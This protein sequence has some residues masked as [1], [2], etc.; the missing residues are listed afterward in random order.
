[1]P[2]G[3][4]NWL[5]QTIDFVRIVI[6]FGLLFFVIEQSQKISQLETRI[7]SLNNHI[8]D[9]GE[10]VEGHEIGHPDD[11]PCDGCATPMMN[12]EVGDLMLDLMEAL[13][14]KIEEE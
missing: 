12:D 6:L 9:I 13:I 7:I 1:M 4:P 5:Y 3:M 8:T 2:S 11:K 10:F 14:T